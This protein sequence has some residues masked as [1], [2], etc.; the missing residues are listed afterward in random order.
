MLP[1]NYEGLPSSRNNNLSFSS[2]QT[3]IS[4][5]EFS[6]IVAFQIALV[7]YSDINYHEAQTFP[8]KSPWGTAKHGNTSAMG[9]ILGTYAL[10]SVAAAELNNP[11]TSY[12]GNVPISGQD[13][14]LN[15]SLYFY[16][17]IS[18]LLFFQFFFCIIVAFISNR[19]TVG[20]DQHVPLSVLLRPVA[21]HLQHV[22]GGKK[23]PEFH[24]AKKHTK[25]IYEKAQ[26]GKWVLNLSKES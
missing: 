22:S 1:P 26:G 9:Y 25:V 4:E 18:L 10:G 23:T 14:K 3:S 21:E 24:H 16:L 20:P 17:I 8:P 11:P 13:F 6:L 12:Y 15:H 19:V 7:G 5:A 2:S